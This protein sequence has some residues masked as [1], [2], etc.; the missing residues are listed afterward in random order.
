MPIRVFPSTL[1]GEPIEEHDVYGLTLDDWMATNVPGYLAGGHQPISAIHNGIV[2]PPDEWGQLHIAR[3]DQLDLRIQPAGSAFSALGSIASKL[4]NAVFGFLMPAAPSLKQNTVA[5][6]QKIEL[7]NVKANQPRL[8]EVIEQHFGEHRRYPSFLQPPRRYFENK[9]DQWVEMLLCIG[10]GRYQVPAGQRAVGDTPLISLGPDAISQVYQPGA[11]LSADPS[12]VWWHSVSEVGGTSTGTAGLEL[13][14]TFEVA[15]SPEPTSFIFNGFAVDIPAGAGEYPEGWASG[16]IVRIESPLPY[17]VVKGGVRD[18]V[19]GD[20]SELQPF[21]GQVVEIAGDNAGL[22]VVHSYA[23]GSPG[24]APSAGSPSS[25]AGSGAPT[26]LDFGV[27][28][29]LIYVDLDRRYT[30]S[31]T[32]TASDA[33]VLVAMIN[34]SLNATPLVASLAGGVVVLTEQSP[35]R[36]LP[37]SLSGDSADVF[38]SPSYTLGS[39]TTPGGAATPDE[40]TLSFDDL[41]PVATLDAGRQLMAV[42]YRGLRYRI[43]AAGAQAI[44]VERLTDAGATDGGWSGF[45]LNETTSGVLE[46]DGSTVEGDW[47]GPFAAC[48]DGE[49][50]DCIEWDVM[51]PGGLGGI[52]KKGRLYG[53]GLSTEIQYRDMSTAGDWTTVRND[54]A[55]A[56]LDQLAFTHREELP[57]LMRPEVRMRRIGAKSGST[58]IQDTVQWYGLK[59]R[60][61]GKTAYDG[62]TTMTLRLRIGGRLAAQSENQVN[63][64]ATRVLPVRTGGEWGVETPTR[65]IAPAFAEIARSI[66][67]TDDEID[68]GELDRLDAIWTARGDTFDFVFNET[69]VRDALN[70]VLGAGFAEL[71]VSDGQLIPVRDEPRTVLEQGYSPEN[72]VG[73]LRRQFRHFEMNEP[74]GVE[75]EFINRQTWEKDVVRCLLPGDLGLKLEKRRAEGVT[76]RTRVW[77]IGMRARLARRYRRWDYSFETELDAL[78]SRYLSYCPLIDDIPGYGKASIMLAIED[79]GDATL[80]RVSEPLEWIDGEDHVVAY[81]QADGTLAGPFPAAPGPGGFELLTDI[82]QPWPD[83]RAR[84]EPPHVYFG[85]SSRWSF[86]ALIRSINPQGMLSV[87]V[88]AENYDERV[89]QFDDAEAPAE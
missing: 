47:S 4:I 63:V 83:L 51:M 49:L 9:R 48:P 8:G 43:T 46:L 42:G 31:L 6:G 84:Q 61:Q 27:T 24:G 60:L 14:A 78:N 25:V 66:G 19:R 3:H 7:A 5:E 52:D 81:R 57:G 70:A 45:I 1:P 34:A 41:S 80:V 56:T 38:G 30:V 74:D 20:M 55:E 62:I 39:A 73:P 44:T 69:T 82:P 16:M 54:Y 85:T 79:V 29:A 35:Y 2:V 15:A 77:R 18:V 76:D 58:Q 67:Y 59:A 71:T 87:A 50:T 53:I 68:F 75:V 32:A 11:D 17:E 65:R 22:Y 40:I 88:Q 10:M 12:A 37:I 64:I 33:A 28:P 89:Y 23:P 36:G 86:P 21:P 72:M 26:R 13:R